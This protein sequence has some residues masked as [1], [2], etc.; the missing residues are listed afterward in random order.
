LRD[1]V[2]WLTEACTRYWYV[3]EFGKVTWDTI[4][5]KFLRM[6]EWLQE[7][8]QWQVV[9]LKRTVHTFLDPERQKWKPS[10]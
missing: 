7:N 2:D 6:K 8:K 3:D 10:K 4:A 9:S 5:Q 1:W